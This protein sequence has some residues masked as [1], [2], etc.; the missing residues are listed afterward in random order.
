MKIAEHS[1]TTWCKS[2]KQ[3]AGFGPGRDLGS[4]P[5][6]VKLMGF[7]HVEVSSE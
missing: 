6:K 2:K 5:H 7:G 3:N 1:Q 4:S